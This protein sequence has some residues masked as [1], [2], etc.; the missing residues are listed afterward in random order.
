MDQLQSSHSNSLFL[1][2]GDF[3]CHHASWLSVGTSLT[4]HGTSAKAFC[5][6][7]E[8]TQSVNFSTQISTNGTLSLLDL[9]LTNFP[10]NICCSSSAP[11]GSSYHV[12]VKVDFSLA[13]IGEPPQLWEEV[14]SFK[15]LGL[16][17]CHDLSWESYI[18]NHGLQSQ[19]PTG[20]P[21]S[22]KVLYRPT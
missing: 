7:L 17:L 10:E 4:C 9:I 22:C 14:L 11:I 5:D 13:V 12:L 15:L 1:I 20:N 8:L 19:S 6:S 2:C 18:S 3:N 21:P 16:T